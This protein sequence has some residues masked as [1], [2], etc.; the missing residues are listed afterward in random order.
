MRERHHLLSNSIG[1]YA[2]LIG[3]LSILGAFCKVRKLKSL[4]TVHLCLASRREFTASRD[5]I[6]R[7]SGLNCRDFMMWPVAA[8]WSEPIWD[9]LFYHPEQSETSLS[10]CESTIRPWAQ[11]KIPMPPNPTW[12]PN[13]WVLPLGYRHTPRPCFVFP[14]VE[15]MNCWQDHPYF[16]SVF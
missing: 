2:L 4:T 10:N 16:L 13:V 7:V 3:K 5:S 12:L 8:S 14:F 15:R 6:L 1:F 11:P 9:Q